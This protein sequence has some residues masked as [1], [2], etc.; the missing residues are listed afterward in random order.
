MPVA[1]HTQGPTGT[2]LS[3]VPARLEQDG[4]APRRT[5]F[6]H[7]HELIAGLGQCVKLTLLRLGGVRVL[8][9]FG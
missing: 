6:A 8:L 5:I 7:G 4:H 2:V 1:Q 9:A 3:M